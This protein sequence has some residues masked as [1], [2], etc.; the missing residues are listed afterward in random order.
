VGQAESADGHAESADGHGTGNDWRLQLGSAIDA[1]RTDIPA[2]C[3]KGEYH[4]DYSIFA[5]DITFLDARAPSFQLHGKDLYHQTLSALSW[6]VKASSDA[7]AM[8][9]TALRPPIESSDLLV[10]WRITMW[11]KSILPRKLYN[12][13]PLMSLGSSGK[14]FLLEGYSRYDF[15]PWSAI[16]SKHTIEVTNPPLGIQDLIGNA[17]PRFSTQVVPGMVMQRS[18]LTGVSGT[19]VSRMSVGV[20]R[21][22]KLGRRANLFPYGLPKACKDDF[23]CNGG[24]ANFPLQCC[25]VPLMGKICVAP[26]DF[27]PEPKDPAYVPLPVPT[28]DYPGV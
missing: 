22:L 12:S 25:E 5:D 15:D 8:E 26:D 23:E 19:R 20:G 9:I 7:C 16:I 6:A 2:L 14:P 21:S 13:N 18:G 28:Q 10:R 27:A 1:L 4:P 3:Q 11:P 24:T 17:V